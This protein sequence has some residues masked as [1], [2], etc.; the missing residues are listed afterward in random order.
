MKRVTYHGPSDRRRVGDRYLPRGVPV[1][2][3]NHL[4]DSLSGA[5]VTVEDDSD[6]DAAAGGD[7]TDLDG[8]SQ[9]E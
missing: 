8:G 9:P 1:D 7:P 3:P 5:N 4:A 2:L 6:P